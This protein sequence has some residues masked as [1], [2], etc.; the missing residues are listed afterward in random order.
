MNL[1]RPPSEDSD[2]E[3]ASVPNSPRRGGEIAGFT[4]VEVEPDTEEDP[5]SLVTTPSRT[6]SPV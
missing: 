1:E 2:Y 6:T 5:S 3:L 4:A